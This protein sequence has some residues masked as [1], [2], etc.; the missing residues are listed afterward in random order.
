MKAGL[1]VVH[2]QVVQVDH[3]CLRS[4]RRSWPANRRTTVLLLDPWRS[5]GSPGVNSIPRSA[6]QTLSEDR[7]RQLPGD[8]P[9]PFAGQQGNCLRPS[10]AD[11]GG[12]QAVDKGTRR[13]P[14]VAGGGQ[15]GAHRDGSPCMRR[16]PAV[17]LMRVQWLRWLRGDSLTG[18]T[19]MPM[20]LHGVLGS[21][22][23]SRGQR[24]GGR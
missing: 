12:H 24:P 19:E 23:L 7:E 5:C 10:R 4:G 20:P 6:Q 22:A 1:E 18:E 3:R 13:V 17:A 11:V 15:V 2:V 16:L 14:L 9:S 8:G 21:A